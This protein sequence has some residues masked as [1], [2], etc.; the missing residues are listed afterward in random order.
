[1]A[2]L[3]KW[4]MEVVP[5][6]GGPLVV[7]A[8][9]EP[10]A[11]GAAAAGLGRTVAHTGATIT[12]EARQ[13]EERTKALQQDTQTSQ[14]ALEATQGYNQLSSELA[15][16]QDPDARAPKWKAF[17]T[18]QRTRLGEIGDDDVRERAETW[19]NEQTALWD[20]DVRKGTWRLR[21]KQS[22]D[23]L[24]ALDTDATARRDDS[25]IVPQLSAM[26]QAGHMAAGDANDYL[27]AKRREIRGELG[28]DA[29]AAKVF[30]MDHGDAVTALKDPATFKGL[31]LDPQQVSEFRD[32]LHAQLDVQRAAASQEARAVEQGRERAGVQ[33]IAAAYRGQ[34]DAAATIEAMETGAMRP[35]DA[36]TA[37]EIA[38]KGPA[39]ENDPKTYAELLRLQDGLARG[40]VE[41]AAVRRYAMAH[42]TRLKPATVDAA[43]RAAAE[44]YS[45]QQQAVNEAVQRARQQ[46]VT[47][48]DSTLEL[49]AA[50]GRGAA[51]L[52]PAE[53]KRAFQYRLVSYLSDELDQYVRAHPEATREEITKRGRQI[54]TSLRQQTQTEQR[55]TIDAWERAAFAP[56]AAQPWGEVPLP[57]PDGVPAGLEGLWPQLNDAEKQTVRELLAAGLS[58]E[59]ILEEARD[60]E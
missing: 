31:A 10:G 14:Y 26:V 54:E 3:P 60:A 20:A 16:E 40:A 50:M 57:S 56:A 34:L 33:A 45:P 18:A 24:K 15:M 52:K 12:A 39:A 25:L 58:I 7:R 49:L 17:Q 28:K 38:T 30:Q 6:G 37:L 55:T 32:K 59:R 13:A 51:E 48:T 42:A 19:L 29:I 4:D 5:T 47:V 22:Y 44:T 23:H 8:S 27:Q 11:A 9:G 46:F 41:P 35:E 53:D 36:R 43:L 1:M 2:R 21:L